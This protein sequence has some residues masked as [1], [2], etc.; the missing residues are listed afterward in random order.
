[1]IMK[2]TIEDLKIFNLHNKDESTIRECLEIF[3]DDKFYIRSIDDYF[4][5][6]LT[7]GKKLAKKFK[8]KFADEMFCG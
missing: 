2:F 3:N 6:R 8:V 4:Q 7:E 5:G 1:M